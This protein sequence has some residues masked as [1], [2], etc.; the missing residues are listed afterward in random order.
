MQRPGDPVVAANDKVVWIKIVPPKTPPVPSGQTRVYYQLQNSSTGAKTHG[1]FV[2]DGTSVA[3]A[4]TLVD[5]LQSGGDVSFEA[6]TL[7]DTKFLYSDAFQIGSDT[8]DFVNNVN[9]FH[10]S[11]K[12]IS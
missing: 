6:H 3:W 8:S 2:L 11:H 7:A 9:T 10:K 1:F 5:R 12:N 4:K